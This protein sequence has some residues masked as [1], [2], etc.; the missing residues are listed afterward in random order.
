MQCEKYLKF[1]LDAVVSS[2]GSC[3]E[4]ICH[5]WKNTVQQQTE[6][7]FLEKFYLKTHQLIFKSNS[8]NTNSLVDPF[9]QVKWW[10]NSTQISS[11]GAQ[12]DLKMYKTS[13][14][15]WQIHKFAFENV[16]FLTIENKIYLWFSKTSLLGCVSK[17]VKLSATEKISNSSKDDFVKKS[18]PLSNKRKLSI[19]LNLPFPS[20]SFSCVFSTLKCETLVL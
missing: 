1:N 13:L 2:S 12:A 7:L 16:I 14:Q 17:Q 5:Q 11:L 18:L 19:L 3:F 6:K 20:L 10:Q 4:L 9:T 15:Y 8:R